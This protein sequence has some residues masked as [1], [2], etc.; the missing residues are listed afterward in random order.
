MMTPNIPSWSLVPSEKGLL[1]SVSYSCRK[2]CSAS[3]GTCY[4]VHGDTPHPTKGWLTHPRN[5]NSVLGL[6]P[7]F[8][9][10]TWSPPGVEG[11]WFSFYWYSSSQFPFF[12]LSFLKYWQLSYLFVF[13]IFNPIR[14]IWYL[15]SKETIASSSRGLSFLLF[16]VLWS[17]VDVR[18]LTAS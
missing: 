11:G 10:H 13:H 15:L 12:F 18:P 14:F 9:F 2:D 4:Q 3:R 8:P 17:G 6:N 5:Q 16:L 7:C 1:A